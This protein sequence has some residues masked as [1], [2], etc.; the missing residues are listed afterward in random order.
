MGPLP[1]PPTLRQVTLWGGYVHNPG[2]ALA[3]ALGEGR[4]PVLVVKNARVGEFN[5]K[6]RPLEGSMQQEQLQ[7]SGAA[8][9]REHGGRR[10]AQLGRRSLTAAGKQN[11]P[12][13][14]KNN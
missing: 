1:P 7:R 11:S 3:T 12:P 4:H 8:A 10:A 14:K 5:G 9:A 13:P 2:E 6:V